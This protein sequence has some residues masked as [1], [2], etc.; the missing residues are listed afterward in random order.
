MKKLFKYPFD[1]QFFAEEQDPS[2]KSDDSNANPDVDSKKEDPVAFTPQQQE[3]VN[4]MINERLARAQKESDK[5][6][7][8]AQEA[9]R[10]ASLT[11]AERDREE[12]AQMKK[13]LEALKREKE[14]TTMMSQVRAEFQ[15][16]GYTFD[17]TIVRACIRSDA[18]ETNKAIKSFC[19]AFD[20]AVQEAV[21]KAV[22]VTTPKTSS[23]SKL[24]KAEILKVANRDERLRLI[25]ENMDLFQ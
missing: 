20:G 8:E 17:D 3:L 12:Q 1:I 6:A 21:K 7:K 11:Q 10:L 24:T 13:E 9:Q 22:N 19:K 2:G 18:E 5:K 25:R 15:K 14:E 16:K 4:R 23:T